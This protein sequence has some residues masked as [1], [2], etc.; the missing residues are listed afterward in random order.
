MAAMM[1]SQ[2]AFKP[3]FTG[4]RGRTSS[5]RVHAAKPSSS[6]APFGAAAAAAFAS[7]AVLSAAPALAELNRLEAAA[8]G[9]FGNGTALQVC[10]CCSA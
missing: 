6:S 9:E 7:A 5:V 10:V 8:G 4:S 1:A 2:K 3:A